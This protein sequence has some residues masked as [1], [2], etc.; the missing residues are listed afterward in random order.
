MNG[1]AGFNTAKM[2]LPLLVLLSTTGEILWKQDVGLSDEQPL[3]L[4]QAQ[5]QYETLVTKRGY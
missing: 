5:K 2:L 1:E 4:Y 3:D